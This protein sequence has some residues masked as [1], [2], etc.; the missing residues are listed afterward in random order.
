M[1]KREMT[2]TLPPI[3]ISVHTLQPGA[4][5]S[6]CSPQIMADSLSFTLH[7][8]PWLSGQRCPQAGG[9]SQS[10]DLF[11]RLMPFSVR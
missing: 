4:S 10:A 6:A 7:F 3:D 11:V 9:G 2:T 1:P 8:Q 5:I